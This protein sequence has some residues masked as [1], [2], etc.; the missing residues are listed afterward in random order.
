MIP[1]SYVP[2]KMIP[3]TETG[4]LDIQAFTN[5]NA[6]LIPS[7]QQ[8]AIDPPGSR[9]EEDLVSI[10]REVLNVE[11]IGI[12]QSFLDV[13]GHSL[14]AMQLVNRIRERLGVEVSLRDFLDHLTIASIA[15]LVDAERN[16][17]AGT[18]RGGSGQTRE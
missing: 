4:K 12:H 3:K 1:S 13:G 17:K 11:A 10:W 6:L 18:F 15:T 14:T 8:Q 7:V 2:V 16:E 5:S 9:T